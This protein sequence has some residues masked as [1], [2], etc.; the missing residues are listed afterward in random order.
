MLQ[1]QLRT[2]LERR[3]LFP[4]EPA[5]LMADSL[6]GW[7]GTDRFF[8]MG[9]VSISVAPHLRTSTLRLRTV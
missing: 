4:K 3:T 6:V 9:W 5:E 7:E 2:K 1:S 8:T